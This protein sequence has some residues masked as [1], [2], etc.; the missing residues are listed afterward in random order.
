MAG[1]IKEFTRGGQMT[2]H[3]I[4]MMGQS[5]KYVFNLA[6]LVNILIFCVIFVIL[7][8]SYDRYLAVKYCKHSISFLLNPKT[9]YQAVSYISA[10]GRRMRASQQQFLSSLAMQQSILKIQQNLQQAALNAIFSFIL[11][12]VAV[13][14]IFLHRSKSLSQLQ[15]IRGARIVDAK[16]L[17]KLVQANTP[18]QYTIAGV[19]LVKNSECQ[20]ILLHG[21]TGTGK[22]VVMTDL[23]CQVRNKGQK[24][25]VYDCDGSYI[26]CYYRP[27]RDVLLNALDLRTVCWNPWQDCFEP[28]DYEAYAESKMPLHLSSSDPFWINSARTIL[29]IAACNMQD[30]NPT[31]RKLL[32]SILTEDATKLVRLLKNT[33]AE[34]LVSD[35]IEKTALSIKSTLTT[36]C[37]SLLY[38]PEEQA[39]NMFS[40]RK[41]ITG[42]DLRYSS[43][44]WLF[45]AAN[46]QKAPALRSL[47][48][49]WLDIA[50]RAMLSL[51]P[52]SDRRTWFFVDELPSLHQLP[53]LDSVLAE[54]RKFGC[55]FVGAIQDLHQLH[56]VYGREA[57]ESLL[58]LFNTA[59]TFRINSAES[60]NWVERRYG[61]REIIETKE[62]YSYG[63]ND[64]RDGVTLNKERRREPIILSSEVMALNDLEAF[65][66]LPGEFPAAKISL[67]YQAIPELEPREMA[68]KFTDINILHIDNLDL[69]T[70]QNL[71]TKIVKKPPIKLDTED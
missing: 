2:M 65:L 36:Y 27:D 44:S 23:M 3:A 9:K 8:N 51:T 47:L 58:S 31:T 19:P 64:V 45:I 66:K 55:C 48:T 24:G 68:R 5:S 61:T 26:A 57:A 35:K 70:S 32:A 17:A 29:A 33:V 20:H 21:T 7:S 59:V 60:A 56:K 52:S 18:S 10:S 6:L 28:A 37:K 1:K 39:E 38:L 50:I 71:D 63:A 54:G 53:S 14:W 30:D 46:K 69:E 15:Q 62:G 42:E 43:D 4:R 16:I 49:A 40:I 22:S 41:W 12:L 67:K 13:I 11:S 25:I 34:P